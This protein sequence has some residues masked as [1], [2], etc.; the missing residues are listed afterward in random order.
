[1]NKV[2]LRAAS[3]RY[4]AESILV[5]NLYGS[6]DG[7][8]Y[9][10]WEY[11][12]STTA[13]ERARIKREQE[14]LKSKKYRYEDEEDSPYRTHVLGKSN[15]LISCQSQVECVSHALE[16]LRIR[17]IERDSI[18]PSDLG[19]GVISLQVNNIKNYETFQKATKYLS[20]L[21]IAEY[22]FPAKFAEDMVLY[23][24]GTQHF[25]RSLFDVLRRERRLKLVTDVDEDDDLQDI[26]LTYRWTG[27]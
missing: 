23:E 27:R 10:V 22:V 21:S 2:S 1:V 6:E 24:I 4:L 7:G 25:V 11:F 20:E 13:G 19:K 9:T 14:N 17:L 16:A 26:Q 8:W 3:S 12:E 15:I 18:I 5:G